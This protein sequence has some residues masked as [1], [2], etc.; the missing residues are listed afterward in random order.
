MLT[1]FASRPPFFKNLI[2]Q[3]ITR[4]IIHI[5]ET[6]LVKFMYKLR[7]RTTIFSIRFVYKIMD[8]VLYHVQLRE[9]PEWNPKGL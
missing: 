9:C 2:G 5:V 8:W 4:N 1:N 3:K 6:E 7:Q